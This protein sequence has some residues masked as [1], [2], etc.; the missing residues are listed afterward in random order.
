[1]TPDSRSEVLCAGIVVADAIASPVDEVP[2]PGRLALVDSVELHTGGCALSTASALARLGVPTAL[3]G[4]V[5]DDLFGGVLAR[6]ASARGID[7][8][9]LRISDELTSASVVL[10]ASDGERTFLHNPGA[11]AA[12]TAHDVEGA[13]R[14]S[15]ARWLHI[16]GALVLPSLDGEPLAELLS[17]AGSR[18]VGTSLDPVFDATGTWER[19][20]PCL[21]HLDA[22][23]PN[24]TEAR[25]I[26]GQR[27]AEDCAAWLRDHGVDKVAVKLGRDGAYALDAQAGR[28]VPPFEVTARD[29][30]GAGDAFAAGLICGLLRG[31]PLVRAVRL[32]NAVGALSTTGIGASTA[33]PD[34]EEALAL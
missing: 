19:L 13:L 17:A 24:I 20:H 33:L 8:T 6:Q 4:C 2:E 22:I 12:L 1:M 11:S 28:H 34:L 15:G 5:G 9:G 16:G 25:G 10:D 31:W 29:E 30:T 14:A 18:G 3:S 23:C 26:T 32:G 27:S 21:P 7:T